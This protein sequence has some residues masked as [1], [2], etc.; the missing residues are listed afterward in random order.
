LRERLERGQKITGHT[1]VGPHGEIVSAGT[2][3]VRRL[4]AFEPV[5]TSTL[6]VRPAGAEGPLGLDALESAAG[7]YTGHWAAPRLP[8]RLRVES[9]G[10][11]DPKAH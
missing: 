2:V 5:T 6:L 8:D 4:H 3:G 1:V 10:V 9:V 11:V 7:F